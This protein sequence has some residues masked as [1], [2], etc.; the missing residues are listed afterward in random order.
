VQHNTFYEK[1]P[2]MCGGGKGQNPVLCGDN[3]YISNLR[4][5]LTTYVP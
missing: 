3:F 2:C 1:Q 4:F 5:N